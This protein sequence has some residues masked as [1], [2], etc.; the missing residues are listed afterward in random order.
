MGP[1]DRRAELI[2]C[3]NGAGEL[4]GCAGVEVDTISKSDGRGERFKAPL[5]SNLAVGRKF[6]RRG[7]AED[8]VKAAEVIARKEW[9][10]DECYLYVEKRNKAAVKLYK[11]MGY[12]TVWE[13]DKAKTLVPLQSGKLST[14]PTVIL[15]MKK[16][17]SGLGRWLP[18]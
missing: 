8:L 15:C 3:T 1:M 9:G 4:M 14:A 7:L 13:D 17:L 18:F 11:K 10:F 16:K 6:R 5:M 12:R 2:L